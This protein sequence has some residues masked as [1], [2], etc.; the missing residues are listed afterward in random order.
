MQDVDDFQ[1]KAD[2]FSLGVLVLEIVSGQ[3]VNNFRQGENTESLMSYVSV[4]IAVFYF[5]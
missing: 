1:F 4:V 5:S 3:K 2:V